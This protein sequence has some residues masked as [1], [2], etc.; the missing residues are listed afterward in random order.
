[1]PSTTG[2]ARETIGMEEIELTRKAADLLKA[3]KTYRQQKRESVWRKA[4]IAYLGDHWSR[5]PSTGDATADLT[6]VNLTYSTVNTIQPYITGE[7]PV[8]Y[9]DPYGAGATSTKAIMLQAFLNRT[10]RAQETGSMIALRASV[11]DELINGDGFMKVSWD[12]LDRF[13]ESLEEASTVAK[14]YVDRISPWNVWMDE[15]SDGISN[16]RWA[17]E[18]IWMTIDELKEDERYDVPAG[19]EAGGPRVA[20]DT[21]DKES[22]AGE[23]EWIAVYEFYDISQ[24]IMLTFI[25]DTDA[26]LRVVDEVECP[27]VQL[28]NNP[29]PNSPY[30]QGEV[31][32]IWPLQQELNKTRSEMSTHRRRNAAKVFVKKDSLDPAAI[33][34]LKSPIVGEIV[35]VTGDGPL[36]SL[37]KTVQFSNISADNYN[38]TDVIR[39]DI[40]EITGVTEYQRGA[41]PDIR[42]TATEVNVMEGASNVKLRAKLAGVEIALRRVGELILGIAHD[43]FPDTDAKEMEMHLA[44]TEAE[45]LNRSVVGSRIETATQEGQLEEAAQMTQDLPYMSEAKITPDEQMFDG[46]YEVNVIHNSTQY[47]SPQAQAQTYKEIFLLLA[48]NQEQLTASGVQVNLGEVIKLWLEASD[49]LDVSAIIEPTAQP[50]P[51]Q[52]PPVGM[53]DPL[54]ELAGGAGAPTPPPG[55]NPATGMPPELM[56][57]LAGVAGPQGGPPSAEPSADNSGILPQL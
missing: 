31:E 36:E 44:G 52:A 24:K 17:C 5:T 40:F 2:Y 29:I 48:Q 6:V 26:P 18:R 46:I 8:F 30:H 25:E 10:W 7:E 4:E 34:S 27:I 50:V 28:G 39:T 9:V 3:G 21:E 57:I 13:E 38:M 37:V 56:K 54:A 20:S 33:Q 1:M 51:Q 53:G 11:F 19:I 42:R 32:Q 55:G 49:I 47:R 41:A 12:I 23:S 43:V 45:R 16:S 22:E 35:P 15:W 14:L